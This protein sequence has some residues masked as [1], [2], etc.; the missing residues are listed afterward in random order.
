VNKKG[1]KSGTKVQKAVDHYKTL[2]KRLAFEGETKWL[3]NAMKFV[4]KKLAKYSINLNK[5]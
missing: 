3:A 2:Q 5:I 1:A 4:M